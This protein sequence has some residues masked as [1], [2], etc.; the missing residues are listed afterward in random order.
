MSMSALISVVIPTYYRNELLKN[1]ID[2]VL[3]QE[4][5]PLEIVVVDDS[6]EG[7]AVPVLERYDDVE[8]IIRGKNGGWAAAYEAGIKATSGEYVHLLDDDDVLLDGKITKTVD[9]VLNEPNTGVG[10]TGVTQGG[11]RHAPDPAMS[12]NVL[13]STLRIETFPCYTSS[14]LIDRDI[15]IDVLP[16]PDL[17]AANDVNLMIELSSRTEFNYVDEI[18]V[19]KGEGRNQMWSGFDKLDGTKRV[20]EI[21]DHLYDQYP[22]IRRK[23][24]A[25]VYYQ[26]GFHRLRDKSWTPKTIGCFARATRHA[27]TTS[28][29]VK[30]G[31]LLFASLFGRPGV[32]AAQRANDY[33]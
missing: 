5:E 16:L 6:G 21:Q 1:A 11:G 23:V 14:M 19:K 12:G 2:S 22:E 8:S 20:V 25:D 26:E 24:L 3:S 29:R 17:P 9:V 30:Y 18:L 33:F 32:K 10:Y 4:Y 27:T 15:L 31:S 7:N 13:E 28:D